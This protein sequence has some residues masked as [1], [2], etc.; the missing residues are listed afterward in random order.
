LGGLLSLVG[1]TTAT[2]SLRIELVKVPTGSVADGEAVVTTA[3]V[4][5]ADKLLT[6]VAKQ[7]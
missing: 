6:R 3:P 7:A 2:K 1:E 4:D 5:V